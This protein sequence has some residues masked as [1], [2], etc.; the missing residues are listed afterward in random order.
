MI[1]IDPI[2]T[3]ERGPA[4]ANGSNHAS[5]SSSSNSNSSSSSSYQPN[6]TSGATSIGPENENPSVSFR[7]STSIQQY[8][9]PPPTTESPFAYGG[10]RRLE[11]YS[12]LD[13]TANAIYQPLK[14]QNFSRNNRLKDTTESQTSIEVIASDATTAE[15][16]ASTSSTSSSDQEANKELDE[17]NAKLLSLIECP[18]CLEPICPPVHQCRRGH[19]VITNKIKKVIKLIKVEYRYVM[20]V[21]CLLGVIT[22]LRQMQEPI[23]PMS[24]VS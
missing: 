24:Y 15:P 7:A 17:F 14:L 13:E 5:A 21:F 8:T 11:L 6:L 19:L 1:L 20:F 3:N 10:R 16:A 23:T 18:V 12:D 4:G 9:I 2:E 22:G